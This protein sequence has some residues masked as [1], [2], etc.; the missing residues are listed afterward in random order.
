MV[1]SVLHLLQNDTLLHL[2]NIFLFDNTHQVLEGVID[3]VRVKLI[4]L[5][6]AFA[7]EVVAT[8]LRE[9]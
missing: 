7:E 1:C 2:T 8:L 5:A 3:L 6:N 4:A 9:Y